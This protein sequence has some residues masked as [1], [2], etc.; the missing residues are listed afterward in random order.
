MVTNFEQYTADVKDKE[1]PIVDYIV[2]RI[3]LNVGQNSQVTNAQI[4][5]K[6]LEQKKVKIAEPKLRKFIQYI[7]QQNLVP[8]LCATQKG[9]YVAQSVQE[10]QAYTDTVEE[11][12]NG[13]SY[14]LKVMREQIKAYKNG[15]TTTI[16][17]NAT[18]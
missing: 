7:R 16:H 9:Y 1:M 18:V 3:K 8:M 14:T 6:I 15:K 11:R 13:M 4:R 5:K 2:S 12:I 17:T 10:F